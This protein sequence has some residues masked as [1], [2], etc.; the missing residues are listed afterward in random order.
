MTGVQQTLCMAAGAVALLAGL[1]LLARRRDPG[2]DRM[3]LLGQAVALSTPALAIVLVGAGL[4]AS[5]FVATP[6]PGGSGGP[7]PR[8]SVAGQRSPDPRSGP[9]HHYT[10]PAQ[11]ATVGH[12]VED[13]ITRTFSRVFFTF[14][15]PQGGPDRYVAVLRPYAGMHPVMRVTRE[16]LGETT[17]TCERLDPAAPRCPFDARPDTTYFIA[18]HDATEPSLRPVANGHVTLTIEPQ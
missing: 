12:A 16:G 4:L 8:P 11:I 17:A 15:A 3:R 14:R 6:T 13:R 2:T 18:V 5:P 1:A 9:E 7:G 10:P